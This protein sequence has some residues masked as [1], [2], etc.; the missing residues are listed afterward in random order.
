MTA[1]E[2]ISNL[3]KGMYYGTTIKNT[4]TAQD[5]ENNRIKLLDILAAFNAGQTQDALALVNAI[6]SK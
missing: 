5:L 3:G 1:Q 4:V 2:V 6:V